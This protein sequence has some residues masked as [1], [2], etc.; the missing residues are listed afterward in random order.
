MTVFTVQ[1]ASN[2]NMLQSLQF[3]CHIGKLSEKF[4]SWV[5]RVYFWQFQVI[6]WLSLIDYLWSPRQIWGMWYLWWTLKTATQDVAGWTRCN[7]SSLTPELWGIQAEINTFCVAKIH[8]FTSALLDYL[9]IIHKVP[10]WILAKYE[11]VNQSV[12]QSS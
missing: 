1:G 7:Q 10:V 9:F 2:T 6:L 11:P 4:C 12:S 8:F 3:F 5:T